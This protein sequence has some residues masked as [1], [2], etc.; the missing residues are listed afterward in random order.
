MILIKKNP[1]IHQV[2]DN[3]GIRTQGTYTRMSIRDPLREFPQYE[4][5]GFYVDHN[6]N[7]CGGECEMTVSSSVGESTQKHIDTI[8][9]NTSF[10]HV[11]YEGEKERSLVVTWFKGVVFGQKVKDYLKIFIVGRNPRRDRKSILPLIMSW[12]TF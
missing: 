8:V 10:F 3:G 6:F 9:R 12:K 4:V 1:C 7:N 2:H 5:F 11:D